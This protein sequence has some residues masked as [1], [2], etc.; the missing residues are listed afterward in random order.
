[1]DFDVRLVDSTPVLAGI[2]PI[3]N[4]KAEA[5]TKKIDKML[6]AVIISK[7]SY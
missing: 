5:L 7:I 2:Y 6:E 4:V 3:P 1:M